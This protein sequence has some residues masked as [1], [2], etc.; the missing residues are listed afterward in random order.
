M[1]R[2]PTR[3]SAPRAPSRW[4]AVHWP[5]VPLVLFAG[6]L[7]LYGLGADR[8]WEDEG[9]TALL[10][11]TIL[12]TGLPQAWDGVT[13]VAPDF[14]ERLK[15]G[16][17][18]VSHPWLQYYAAAASFALFGESPFAARLPFAL[19]GLATV[20]VLYALAWTAFHRRSIAL[21][22]ALLLSVSVQFLLYARQ[23]RNY[24]F[25]ALFTCLLLWQFLHLRS[26]RSGLT[27]TGL[28]IL[29][30]H[31]HPI[32]LTAVLALAGLSVM[33][34]PLAAQRRWACTSA[35]VVGLYA[36]PWLL[37]ARSGHAQALWPGS[38]QEWPAR[39]LQFAVEYASVTPAVAV[40]A[41]SAALWVR[42]HRRGRTWMGST[43]RP[44]DTTDGLEARRVAVAS[45]VII[46]VEA[47]VMAGTHTPD[48]IWILG[49]HHTPALMPLTILI[50]AGGIARLPTVGW[51]AAVVVVLAAT[52]LGQITPWVSWAA[53]SAA[54]RP[55]AL[56]TAHV[57][58]RPVDR[59]FR[60]T[61]WH[62]GR[63][64]LAP[65]PGVVSAISGY[66]NAH[67]APGDV[68]ITNYAWEA[69]Y[70]HT[71]LPQ[72]AKVSPRFPIYD[73]VHRSGLPAYV[74]STTAVRWLVCRWAFPAYVPEQDC[75]RILADLKAQ[76]VTTT[77]VATIAETL[78]ENRENVHFRRYAGSRYVYPWHDAL[79]DVE[80]YRV[81]WQADTERIHQRAD[82]AF[83]AGQ[84]DVA[85]P[86]LQD[87]LGARPDD[88]RA[89]S[90]TG[91]ALVARGRVHEALE[92]FRR[93][94]DVD[95]GDGI[96]QR[97]L[98]NVLLDT[99]NAA[100]ALPH[101]RRAI[102][103]RPSDPDAH[104]V[105]GRVLAALDDVEGAAGAFR[106]ALTLEPSHAD[107]RANLGAIEPARARAARRGPSRLRGQSPVPDA[108]PPA[109][110]AR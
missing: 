63:S 25:H 33:W 65:S 84:F 95:P 39:L 87:Y 88:A 100:G 99:G 44:A 15:F 74:T 78:Y 1:S 26:W 19:A 82:A 106:A 49:L 16:F 55:D 6:T 76:A 68:V 4:A 69:V 90:R 93:A 50:L 107:A 8:L 17:V 43:P 58:P 67:A 40:I 56:V 48:D 61:L 105:L 62:F 7:M 24:S 71:R 79:P 60:T 108:P 57:P 59:L 42:R 28:G 2:G 31:T 97:N 66:L 80:V 47:L 35:A 98:A 9:D 52:R 77:R 45:A 27:F 38:L 11:R 83:D 20:V 5:V 73:T 104:E 85:I 37:V 53:S 3:P 54:R 21:G 72:G 86:L 110:H 103:I 101:A 30:F 89:L 23:A 91:I 41:V 102:A 75:G 22:A 32:G 96:G 18:M 46:A 14:G 12:R 92:Y 51:Q 70:F 94:A 64:L 29:L 13:F 36:I 81:D 10:A 109:P 34:P